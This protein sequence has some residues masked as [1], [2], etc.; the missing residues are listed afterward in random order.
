MHV[1]N[2]FHLCKH[3]IAGATLLRPDLQ[4]PVVL[5]AWRPPIPLA[6]VPAKSCFTFKLVLLVCNILPRTGPGYIQESL[7]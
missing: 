7:G 2:V 5:R 1:V 4:H 3:C 6:P